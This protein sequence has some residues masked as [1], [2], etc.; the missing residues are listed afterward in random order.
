MSAKKRFWEALGLFG[1]LHAIYIIVSEI[2]LPLAVAVSTV[3][4]GYLGSFPLMWI[5]MATSMAFMATAISIM[6]ISLYLERLNPE[7]KISVVQTIF[8]NDLTPLSV[9]RQQRRSGQAFVPSTRHI[10]YGQL[11]IEVINSSSFP[12]SV[13]LSEASSEIDGLTPPRSN[14]P[15]PA[16]SIA[17]GGRVWIHD[18][19]INLGGIECGN[20][21]A[22][23][24]FTI[25][26]GRPKEEK[27]LIRHR[28]PVEI[29]M[30]PSGPLRSIYFHPEPNI[31]IIF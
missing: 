24:D 29:F 28:G 27:Y 8:L 19:K 15:K 5:I 7:N 30:E 1:H 22:K 6:T 16:S 18:D 20:I 13:Y 3:I 12:I 31:N 25:K 26:Y 17:P 23:I 2:F 21:S 4:A 10:Q 9:S 11:G 14:F